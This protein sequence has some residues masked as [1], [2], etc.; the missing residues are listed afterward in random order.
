MPL[1]RDKV[2]KVTKESDEQILRRE[3]QDF[4]RDIGKHFDVRYSPTTEVRREV[5]VRC[6]IDLAGSDT[7]ITQFRQILYSYLYAKSQ[8][9]NKGQ[10]YFTVRDGQGILDDRLELLKW[11]GIE[12]DEVQRQSERKE[13]YDR[14]IQA[15]IEVCNT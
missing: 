5:R 9:D 6:E 3:I 4:N 1:T 12:I 8:Q 10:L 15:L 14:H 7:T 2:E 11:L 13:V